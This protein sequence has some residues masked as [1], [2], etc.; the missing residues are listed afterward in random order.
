MLSEA[1]NILSKTKGKII[2]E[3]VE[4]TSKWILDRPCA[5]G[6]VLIFKGK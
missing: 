2:S 6:L 3:I 1:V 5:T 4:I